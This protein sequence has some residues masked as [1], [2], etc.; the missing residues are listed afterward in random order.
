MMRS[1]DISTIDRDDVSNEKYMCV[2]CVINRFD[3]W[4]VVDE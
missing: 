2:L 1:V 4:L 3:C